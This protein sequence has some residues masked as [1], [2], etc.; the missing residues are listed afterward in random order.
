MAILWYNHSIREN[1]VMPRVMQYSKGSIPYFSGDKDE[2]IFILQ[3]G[4][5]ILSSQDI[6]TNSKNFLAETGR[7]S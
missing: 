5:L 7:L 4:I 2:R 6:E 1:S 3:K